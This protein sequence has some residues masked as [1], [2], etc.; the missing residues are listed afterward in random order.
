MAE[1]NP[2]SPHLRPTRMELQDLWRHRLHEAKNRHDWSVTAF[3][4]AATDFHI[5]PLPAPDGNLRLVQAIQAERFGA[6]Q[7]RSISARLK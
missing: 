1:S 5:D 4:D 7:K 6:S 2:K 3:R